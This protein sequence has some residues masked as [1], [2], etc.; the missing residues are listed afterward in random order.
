MTAMFVTADLIL[1]YGEE[2]T[3][4]CVSI[5]IEL[6]QPRHFYFNGQWFSRGGS[7]KWV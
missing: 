1:L 7:M 6:Y 2:F 3:D 4:E 5:A